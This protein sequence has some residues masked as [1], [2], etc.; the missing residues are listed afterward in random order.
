MSLWSFEGVRRHRNARHFHNFGGHS[1]RETPLPI[2]NREV[3]PACAD[4]TRRATSRESRQPPIIFLTTASGTVRRRRSFSGGPQ[5][6]APIRI[7]L[8]EPAY[9]LTDRWVCHEQRGQ[10]FLEE[11]ID[12]VERLGRGAAAKRDELRGLVQPHERVG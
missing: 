9:A 6:L 7:E 2:P 8:A 10:S 11:R 5:L 3:K 4:G 1:G 12:R